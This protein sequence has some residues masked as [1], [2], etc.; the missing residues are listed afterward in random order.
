VQYSTVQHSTV[1][2]STLCC[3]LLCRVSACA[4]LRRVVVFT[5]A[6]IPTPGYTGLPGAQGH[7]DAAGKNIDPLRMQY[8]TVPAFVPFL[9]RR[10][11][12][13]PECS[14][15]LETY[16]VLLLRTLYVHEY[17]TLYPLRLL[18]V[19][20]PR[21]QKEG[22]RSSGVLRSLR[23][24]APQLHSHG[25]SGA[26]EGG[27][28][29]ICHQSGEGV[30]VGM[31]YTVLYST[32]SPYDCWSLAKRGRAAPVQYTVIVAVCCA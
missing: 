14:V 20:G 21:V 5:G 4:E 10:T 11:K 22:K 30:T 25:Q 2:Y 27:G 7:L 6:G 13:L 24:C 26:H 23:V 17:C 1:Q 19:L 8:C 18:F 28:G 15:L 29:A 12:S 3:A 16:A 31:I 9:R 32:L